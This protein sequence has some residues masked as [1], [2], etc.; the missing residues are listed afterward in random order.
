MV[1]EVF[2]KAEGIKIHARK[3]WEYSFFS[4]PYTAHRV[5]A[6][7]DI[8]QG[9]DFGEVALSPVSGEVYKIK[10]FDT[11]TPTKESLPEYLTMIRVGDKLARIM[12]IEPS[13]KVGEKIDAGDELGRFIRNGFFFYWVDAGM[14]VEVRDLDD[15]MRSRGTYELKPLFDSKISE[16]D[17]QV[18]ELSGEVINVTERNVTLNLGRRN[19]AKVGDSYAYMDGATLIGY[20]GLLGRFKINEL[21][22]FNGIRIGKISKVGSYMSMFEMED[23]RVK[24]NDVELGG[25]SFMFNSPVIRLL[26]K[27]YDKPL[28]NKGEKIILEIKNEVG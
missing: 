1:M 13:V 24:A 17:K 26:P 3:S 8:Y 11:P 19:V 10:K 4:S 27:K 9:K 14:H 25:F 18:R 5:F 23:L 28:F 12:H 6:A 7:V 16:E 20:G 22:F 21:V 2:A 15:Y